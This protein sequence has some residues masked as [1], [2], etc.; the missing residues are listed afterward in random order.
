VIGN[1]IKISREKQCDGDI[2]GAM[3]RKSVF[4]FEDRIKIVSIPIVSD[5]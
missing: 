1:K 5:E 4:G 2:I 3:T